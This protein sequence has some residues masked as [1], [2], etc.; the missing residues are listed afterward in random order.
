MYKIIFK[1]TVSWDEKDYGHMDEQSLIGRWALIVLQA[2]N[3]FGF[4]L[5]CKFFNKVV[6]E[7]SSN[8]NGKS[9]Q[10]ESICQRVANA[11][12]Q[13]PEGIDYPLEQPAVYIR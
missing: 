2:T 4:Q 13:L 12:D 11:F 3:F 9:K 6:G 10:V 7:Y 8:S 5:D 1:W